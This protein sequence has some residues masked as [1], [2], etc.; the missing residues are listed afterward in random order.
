MRLEY[1]QDARL[2]A[3]SLLVEDL[4]RAQEEHESSGQTQQTHSEGESTTALKT[5]AVLRNCSDLIVSSTF[6]YLPANRV[7]KPVM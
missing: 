3:A 1:P 2:Q 7:C 5:E 6:L 4:R